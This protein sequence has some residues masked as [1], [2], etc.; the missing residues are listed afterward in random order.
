MAQTGRV[1]LLPAGSAFDA[2]LQQVKGRLQTK[3]A[4]QAILRGAVIP[5]HL[6]WF[7][8]LSTMELI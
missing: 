8:T 7:R 5:P 2:A 6:P 3:V 1:Q 4:A